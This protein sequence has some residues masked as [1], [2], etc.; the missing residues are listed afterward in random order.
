LKIKDLDLTKKPRNKNSKVIKILL[1][2]LGALIIGTGVTVFFLVGIITND[3]ASS[4]FKKESLYVVPNNQTAATPV[5]SG[6]EIDNDA[7]A[8]TTPA[9]P[10]GIHYNGN[11]Y[12]KNENIVNLLFLG[13]DTNKER[14]INMAGYRSDVIMVCA[15]DVEKKAATLISIP[16]DTRT[17]VHKVNE[18]TGVVT[19]TL[20]WKINT[21]YSYGGGIEKY[22]YPNSMACVQM[23]LER[24]N[25]L[26]EPLDFTLD[27]PVYLYASMDMD[28]IPQ[29]ASSVGGVPIT[30]E[31]G[32][33]GVGSKGQ[34]VTLKYNNAVEYLT[35]RHDTGG[36][37]DRAR[38][39]QK[40]MIALAKKIKDMDAP[41]IL[42]KM[43]DDLTRVHTNLDTTQMLDL[44]KILMQT[45]ID[46]IELITIPGEGKKI[47][48]NYFI[49]HD[50][51]ATLQI[52]L[53]VYYN[54]VG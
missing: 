41:S 4:L 1:G 32:I 47:N 22:S 2:V 50:E 44:A 17:T 29:V 39:Q 18:D 28:G 24:K 13:I 35:N 45:D 54:K 15:V 49:L 14:R 38:R 10:E 7:S 25:Q 42:T 31:V 34:T 20:E 3:D 26:E 16:R 43:A 53:D 12:T 5:A 52:L 33:P 27:I 37:L 21:A 30:L 19:E 6:E 9:P 11:I 48:G 46:A 36:D 8:N 51:A 40:F 23:F